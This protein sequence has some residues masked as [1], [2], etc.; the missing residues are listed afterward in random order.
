MLADDEVGAVG[1]INWMLKEDVKDHGYVGSCLPSTLSRT[2]TWAR[3]SVSL[4]I[5]LGKTNRKGA[6][7]EAQAPTN[8]AS[9]TRAT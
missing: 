9:I 3:Y 8:E 4:Y 2:L 1:I 7:M 5:F 6:F